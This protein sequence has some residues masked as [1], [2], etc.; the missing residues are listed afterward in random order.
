[1][2]Q[3]YRGEVARPPVGFRRPAEVAEGGKEEAESPEPEVTSSQVRPSVEGRPPDME[4][5]SLHFVIKLHLHIYDYMCAN[6]LYLV[7]ENSFE[8]FKLYT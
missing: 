4:Q 2:P 7:L 3:Y 8:S 1:V 5:Q 6:E